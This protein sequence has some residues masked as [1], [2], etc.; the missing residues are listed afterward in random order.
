MTDRKIFIRHRV[1]R[2]AQL[3]ELDVADGA[4][5]DLRSSVER[6]GWIHLS[7]DPWTAG[8]PF[9]GWARAF[10]SRGLTGPVI[11]NTKEDAL[12]ARAIEVM[13]DAGLTN[14]FFLDT[15]LPTLVKWT[16]PGD[17]AASFAVRYSRYEGTETLRAFRGRAEWVWVDC[18]DGIPVDVEPLRAFR[19]GYRFCLVSPELQSVQDADLRAFAELYELADAIC[20]KTPA[21]WRAAFGGAT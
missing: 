7:H 17:R 13:R 20:T 11:L 4:E 1:N 15:T 21:R 8:D 18:F 6:P 9:V 10:A 2:I 5:I 19:G 14:F 16:Q 12:E 3:A